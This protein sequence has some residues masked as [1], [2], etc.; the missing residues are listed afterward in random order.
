VTPTRLFLAS[1]AIL[2]ALCL[3]AGPADAAPYRGRFAPDYR[4]APDPDHMPGWDWWKI[5]PYSPYNYG[6]NPYNPIIYPPYPPPYYPPYYAPEDAMRTYPV[7][8]PGNAA[9]PDG[10]MFPSQLGQAVL[11]PHPSGAVKFPPPGAA[12]VQVRVPDAS[13]RILFDGERTYTEG[14][15]RYFITPELPDGKTC[16]YTVSANWKDGGGNDVTKKR[17]V[18]VSAGHTTVVDFTRAAA[19]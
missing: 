2:G 13:A 11:M 4:P 5:Y 7:Y 10:A 3:A 16:H 6:R 15:T 8:G 19:K 12:I 9:A 14:T 1:T 17:E 18:G